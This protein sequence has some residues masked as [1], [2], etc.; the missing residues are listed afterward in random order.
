MFIFPSDKFYTSQTTS[1]ALDY[2][3]PDYQS[4]TFI[5]GLRR[6]SVPEMPQASFCLQALCPSNSLFLDHALPTLLQE[7]PLTANP[8]S[9]FR[10]QLGV[11][12]LLAIPCLISVAHFCVPRTSHTSTITVHFIFSVFT[13][14]YSALDHE[15]HGG[16]GYFYFT[17]EPIDLAIQ[18]LIFF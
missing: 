9:A 13:S 5:Q 10:S 7:S 2:L 14:L 4:L 12:F 3:V 17:I 6:P 18:L 16:K 1:K 11:H 8:H 15:F